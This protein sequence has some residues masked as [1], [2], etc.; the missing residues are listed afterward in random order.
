MIEVLLRPL[1]KNEISVEAWYLLLVVQVAPV[2]PDAQ[3]QVL[4]PVHVPP[5]E[6]VGEQTAVIN[7]GFCLMQ[8]KSR[9]VAYESCM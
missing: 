6:H 4:G 7:E 8:V 9:R 3:L 1:G 2:H 5:L